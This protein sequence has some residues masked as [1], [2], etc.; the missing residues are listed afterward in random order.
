MEIGISK[1]IAELDELCRCQRGHI[2]ELEEKLEIAVKAL[3][4][5]Y[6][7]GGCTGEDASDYVWIAHE[8]LKEIK[9]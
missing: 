3:D 1:A 2:C 4:N 7:N 6:D 8:A 9:E 5:I